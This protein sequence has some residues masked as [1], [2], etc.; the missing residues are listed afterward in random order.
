MIAWIF[1]L[2]VPSGNNNLVF[3][4]FPLI[5]LRLSTYSGLNLHLNLLLLFHLH[6][7]PQD[8]YVRLLFSF[9]RKPNSY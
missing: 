4:L 7:S 6:K 9:H 2:K 3:V 1:W 8:Q 5:Y